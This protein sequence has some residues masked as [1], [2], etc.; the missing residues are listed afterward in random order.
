MLPKEV[1]EAWENREAPAVLGT[2]S[3]DGVPNIIYVGA[4]K[5]YKKTEYDF[6][7]TD[8]VFVVSD[9]AFLKTRKNILSSSNVSLLF[10]SKDWKAFQIKG[11][12]TYETAGAVFDSLSK[13]V[14]PKYASVGAAII[15]IEEVYC[16]AERLV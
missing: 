5:L 1:L 9:S 16:G 4:I 2:V 11:K 15:N 14:D 12:V 7:S 6:I 8:C 13:W 3:A 10:I